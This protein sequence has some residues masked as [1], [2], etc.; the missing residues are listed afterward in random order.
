MGLKELLT[1]D[2]KS[3]LERLNQDKGYALVKSI[4]EAYD[5]NVAP[6][7]IEMNLKT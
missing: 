1:G 6:K 7:F 2:S 3:I 5:K 4:A